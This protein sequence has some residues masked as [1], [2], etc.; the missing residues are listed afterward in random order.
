MTDVPH[1]HHQAAPTA[2]RWAVITISDTRHVEDDESGHLIL[3]ALHNAGHEVLEHLVLPDDMDEI[4][5]TV[6]MLARDPEID[7]VITT[8]G[9]G[10]SV[11]DVSIEAVAPLVGKR[12][13]GFG[14]LF[15]QLSY[16]QIGPSAYLSRAQAATVPAPDAVKVLYQL[17]G[18]PA[19][20]ELA[21]SDLIIPEAGHLFAQ[22]NHGL[23]FA[24]RFKEFRE[25]ARARAS[26]DGR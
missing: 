23:D 9:T 10:V 2:L 18:S 7:G 4:R 22:A 15:R 12:L 3:Q 21:V 11:R 14:E 5:G 26:E 1:K 24:E 25:S 6:S 20:C 13:P 8:G 17:P 16:E 19:A